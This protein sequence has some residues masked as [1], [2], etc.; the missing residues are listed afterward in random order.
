[1]QSTF[2]S[3]IVDRGDAACIIGAGPGGLSAARALKSYGLPYDQFER[4]VDIGGLWDIRN[5]GTPMYESAHFISSRDL[6]GFIDFPMPKDFPDYPS[7]R[8]IL[9]YLRSFVE[10]YGLRENIRFNCSVVQVEKEPDGRWLVEFD[11]GTRGR[12]GALIC[13]NGTNWNPNMPA[14]AGQFTGEIRHSVSYMSGKEFHGKRVLVL[15]AGNSGADIACDAATHAD[16]AYISLRRGYYFIPKHVFGMPADEFGDSGPHLPLWLGRPIMTMLLRFLNGNL[17]RWGLP[18]P[19]HKLFETHPLM[20]SQLLHHLQHGNITVK[21][22]IARLEG[23]S[24]VF[25]DGSRE[26]IDLLLCAT[27]YR[28]GCRYAEKYFEW[29][30]G[31]PQ[32]YLAMFSRQH[33]NLF[34]MGFQDNN[35][36]AFKLFDTQAFTL[37]SYLHA[38]KTNPASA[39]RFAHLIQTDQPDL[40]GGIRFVESNR[41]NGYVDAHA[42][43]NYLKNV[44]SRMGWA[45]LTDS[46]FH[47]LRT[48]RPRPVHTGMAQDAPAHG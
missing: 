15:G 4:H 16:K 18:K 8:Q 13:A 17:T 39:A 26:E 35:S 31:R 36:S 12:Y 24:V 47:S 20:N 33:S 38:S 45:E 44:R 30:D 41:S 48:Q 7:H 28:W 43:R 25:K 22:D 14:L 23:N 11:D 9:S 34:G 1:M 3:S 32:L 5:P 40:S 27:G 21:P 2:K 46:T 6:S 42:F 10:A 37:A 19:D 29:K